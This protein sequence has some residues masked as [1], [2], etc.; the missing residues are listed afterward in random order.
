MG[1]AMWL[2]CITAKRADRLSILGMTRAHADGDRL[3]VESSQGWLDLYAEVIG[4]QMGVTEGAR[5]SVT[6]VASGVSET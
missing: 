2:D 5:A 6:Y 3:L 4:A 1:N